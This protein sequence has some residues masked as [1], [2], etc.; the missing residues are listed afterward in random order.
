MIIQALQNDNRGFSLIELSL[1]L[2]IVGVLMGGV[3]QVAHI[4]RIQAQTNEDNSRLF[5]V[6]DSIANFISENGR[7]PC[8]STIDD[9][10]DSDEFGEETDCADDSV[11][12]DN[13]L[14]D[15]YFVTSNTV[16]GD[17]Y[18]VRIGAV[19]YKALKIERANSYDSYNNR[20]LYAVTEVQAGVDPI[21]GAPTFD[22]NFDGAVEVLSVDDDG[23]DVIENA[24]MVF[25]SLGKNSAGGYTAFGVE[26]GEACDTDN[27]SMD[28][29]NCDMDARFLSKAR[30]QSASAT[31]QY[32]DELVS[33]LGDWLYIWNHTFADSNSIYNQNS[34]FMGI[35]TNT[36]TD[37]VT[38]E[39]GN[40]RV[41]GHMMSTQ[42]CDTDSGKCFSPSQLGGS[43]MICPVSATA[44]FGVG[45]G[46]GKNLDP[47]QFVLS[48]QN[49]N[50]VCVPAL[51][52][53]SGLCISAADEPSFV[54][55]IR[56]SSENGF[57]EMD[58]ENV[59][60]DSDTTTIDMGAPP[61]GI[62][63]K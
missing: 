29:E 9:E 24:S 45:A 25:L 48:V 16:S 11:A 47:I 28:I 61:E 60:D 6:A 27:A 12:I 41:D 59:Y 53:R 46:G 30:A 7:Y 58:C 43:G 42:I 10:L 13:G 63:S 32:D 40:L 54:T 56:V 26:R 14:T 19:P 34:G 38:V 44:E 20:L 4:Q 15:G 39:G 35:G 49:N 52:I 1:L 50:V 18:R 21:G 55:A 57:Y 22:P 5:Q 36:P 62:K 37:A 3:L 8:P 31:G 51:G 17:V 33:N 23:N 2:L